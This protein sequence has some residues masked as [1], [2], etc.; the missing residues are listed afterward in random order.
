MDAG[1]RAARGD[2]LWFIHADTCPPLDAAFQITTTLARSSVSGGCFAVRF[3]SASRHTCFLA[4]LYTQLRRLGLCYGDATL[5][6]R[7]G[8]YERL[9]GF[10]SFPLFEDVEFV[11]RLRQHGRFVCLPAE[12]ITS[13]RRFEGRKFVLTLIWWMVLQMLYWIGVPPRVLARMYAPIRRRSGK[14]WPGVRSQG[15]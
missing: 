3:D 8:D 4:R 1:A 11:A 9:G 2:I 14:R 10:R 12:V 6:V 7:R 15:T 5:F 13:S